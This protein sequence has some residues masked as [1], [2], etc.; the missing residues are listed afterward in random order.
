MTNEELALS[1]RRLY[2]LTAFFGATGFVSYFCARGWQPALS[3]GLGAVGSF[4]NLWLFSWLSDAISPGDHS[5]KPWKAGLFAARYA[6]LLLLGYVIVKA[7]KVNGLAAILGLFVSTVAVLVSLA[8]EIIQSMARS[9]SR[10]G[11]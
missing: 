6:L 4:G 10:T 3:F 2:R 7:L 9:I 1:L 8:F 11:E 5:R